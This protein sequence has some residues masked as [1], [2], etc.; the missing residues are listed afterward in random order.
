[1]EK[2]N[3]KAVF[4]RIGLKLIIPYL[5]FSFFTLILIG[6][7][8]YYNY[9][10]QIDS[11]QK[12][13][14]EI[15]IRASS[16]INCY[17]K[18]IINELD[19]FS[20]EIGETNRFE[21][22]LNIKT[23]K[24]LI[25][26]DPSVY[27]LSITNIKGNEITKIV[28]YDPKSSLELRDISAQEKFKKALEE[29][30][31]LSDVYISEYQ[32]PFISISLP[33]LNE[34]NTKIGVLA[35]EVDLSPM[36]GTISKIQVKKTGY[37]YVVDQNAN[38]IAYKD[39]NLVKENL[40]LKHIQGV[41][42]FLNNIHAIET[43]TSFDN[44]KVIGTWKSIDIA[45]WGMII[46]LPAKEVFQELS[47]FFFIGGASIILFILSIIIIIIIIFKKLLAPLSYLQKGVIEVKDGNLNYKIFKVSKD[48]IGDLAD[49]FNKMTADLKKSRKK[50]EKYSKN[51]ESKVKSRT[52]ELNEK[53]KEIE[54]TK[55]A[56]LN[57]M[58]DLQEV[59]EEL[60]ELDKAKSDF[61]NI[62]SHELKTPLTAISAHLD[63]LDI[64]KPNLNEQEIKS[65]EAIK[66]N[67]SQLKM[68]IGNILEIARMESN[69]FELSLGRMD[70]KGLINE[71]VKNLRVLSKQKGIE[72][73]VEIGKLPAVTADS[74]RVNE[75]ITNL[76]SNAVKFT[77]KGS[78][79]VKAK[80]QSMFVLVS[81][82]D[83]GI[84]IPKDDIDKLFQKF[85]QVDSSIGRRYGGTGLGLSI[86][87]QLVEAHGG[88]IWVRS[89][90]GKG[91]TFSFTLPIKQKKER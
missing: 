58:D 30:V 43:Y 7:L 15:S 69:K 12:I 11:T 19:L 45:G 24:N 37:V 4:S 1:M 76:I 38:L 18:N 89:T 63:V 56:T 60:K 57:I 16:E 74:N 70:L 5:I 26:H 29:R 82:T 46:E 59:N 75:I 50:L 3:I 83:T 13:Q 48:E 73:R 39:V 87:K 10:V 22:N 80:K 6:V 86:T 77:E 17:I 40:N 62:I 55:T 25:N 32:V 23:L 68:L 34:N 90:L 65:L 85:Y 78:V 28:R 84:G 8:I 91:S 2:E 27:S 64:F 79:T 42:N 81:V 41:K 20:K 36:W 54:N 66:R 49:T 14:E 9:N 35:A 88:K 72:L 33:I 47:V 21:K 51:L 52:K 31:Y 44:E 61:L 67:E 71:V 53:L